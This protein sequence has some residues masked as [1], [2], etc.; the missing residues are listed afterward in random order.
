MQRNDVNLEILSD[1]D[2]VVVDWFKGYAQFLVSKGVKYT[3]K[4]PSLFTMEDVFPE[5]EKPYRFINEYQAS[6]FYK[7]APMYSDVKQSLQRLSGYNVPVTFV[8]SCGDHDE[9]KQV[10]T[11]Y[12][13]THLQGLYEG[14]IFLPLGD[15]K[16][17]VLSQYTQCDHEVL[18]IDDQEVVLNV[19]KDCGLTPVLKTMEYNMG[20]TDYA[21]VGNYAQM[22]DLAIDLSYANAPRYGMRR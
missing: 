12:L 10:R 22:V 13:E 1:I 8:T 9:I 5:L 4:M 3:G 17:S 11:H 19:A 20:N 18:M 7:N 14:V 16:R 21:R 15:D 2:G 6:D